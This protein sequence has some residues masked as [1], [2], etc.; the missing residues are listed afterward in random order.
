MFHGKLCLLSLVWKDE[1][2]ENLI[3]YK[4]FFVRSV[5]LI[6]LNALRRPRKLF[7]VPQKD[8]GPRLKTTALMHPFS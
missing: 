3:L 4:I 6:F 7:R 5:V 1:L 8:C 2:S